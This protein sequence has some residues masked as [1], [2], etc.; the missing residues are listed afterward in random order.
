VTTQSPFDPPATDS[1]KP[2]RPRVIVSILATI[3]IGAA[4]LF[5]L[6]YYATTR[7]QPTRTI[8]VRANAEW[9]GIDLFVE[10][11]SLTSPQTTQFHKLGKYVVPFYLWPGKYTLTAKNQGVEVF[12]R[13]VDLTRRDVEDIDLVRAGVT[14]Q[15]ATQPLP[16]TTAATLD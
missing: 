10:G 12:R 13:E 3:V 15:P 9:D 6:F 14:T 4:S 7:P 2:T 1:T 5:V 11:G 16:A 8:V